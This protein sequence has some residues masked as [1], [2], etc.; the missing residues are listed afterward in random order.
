MDKSDKKNDLNVN[1]K[2]KVPSYKCKICEAPAIHSNYG[3]ITCYPCK[4]FF[5]RYVTIAQVC[6]LRSFF[7]LS[8]GN[9]LFFKE[10]INM[11]F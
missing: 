2:L 11:R 8:I 5:K 3:A 1:R 6:C 9:R 4:M 7:F 10:T